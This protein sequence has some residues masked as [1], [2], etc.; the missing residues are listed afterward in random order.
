MSQKR[1]GVWGGW[2][3]LPRSFLAL[4]IL[5]LPADAA[6]LKLST[7]NFDWL[8]THSRADADLP[9]DVRQRAPSDF[10]RLRH[11]A[12]TLHADIV[13]FQEVDGA[14]TA[15]LIFDPSIYKIATID[16]PVVQRVGIAVRKPIA[17]E[18]HEDVTALDV[19]AGDLHPLRDGLDVTLTLPGGRALRVLVVHLK[20][21]CFEESLSLSSRLSCGML[22]RQVAPLA[23]WVAARQAEGVPFVVMGDFN[24]I[25]DTPEEMGAALARAAPLVRVTLG[26]ENPCWDGAPFID[27][28]FLGGD[29][30]S[31]LEPESLRVQ[32]YREVG[33]TWKQ[34]LSDHCPVSVRL[35]VP[36]G[37]A[38][39]PR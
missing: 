19:A 6:E 2:P 9:A 39:A 27:H 12:D 24:R 38:P 8:T 33:A 37:I 13:G 11:Y 20:T 30:R 34:R 31:W 3:H 16:E 18:K 32:I 22:A 36:D 28:I 10:E 29:A 7:W 26:R 5:N 15:A 14:S 17:M 23:G 4:L 25:F 35:R 1:R 21:G